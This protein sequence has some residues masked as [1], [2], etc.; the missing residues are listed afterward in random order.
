ML[1]QELAELE[2]SS[3][4]SDSSPEYCRQAKLNPA[5][6]ALEALDQLRRSEARAWERRRKWPSLRVVVR[7]RKRAL[8]GTSH[9]I[10]SAQLR[11]DVSEG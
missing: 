10:P 3:A 6:Q 11:T 4:D 5:E 2:G 7:V 8:P 1:S 9:T